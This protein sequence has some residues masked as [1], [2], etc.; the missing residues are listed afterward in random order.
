M[1]S[2]ASREALIMGLKAIQPSSFH[3]NEFSSEQRECGLVKVVLQFVTSFHSNEFS[4][5]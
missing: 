1:S 4:S 3:S 2:L 5:E